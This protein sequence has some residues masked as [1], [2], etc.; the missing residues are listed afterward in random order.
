MEYQW[1]SQNTQTSWRPQEMTN[2]FKSIW[3]MAAPGLKAWNTETFSVEQVL[4]RLESQV[5]TQKRRLIKGLRTEPTRPTQNFNVWRRDHQS[6]APRADTC[7]TTGLS[8]AER[9]LRHLGIKTQQPKVS[10][11]D[12]ALRFGNLRR[13]WKTH[14]ATNLLTLTIYEDVKRP[15]CQVNSDLLCSRRSLSFHTTPWL[16]LTRLSW[17]TPRTSAPL[18]LKNHK[19]RNTIGLCYHYVITR[20][21]LCYH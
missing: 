15:S 13:P 17:L 2:D 14:S 1:I 7:P 9:L 8:R 18:P 12:N 20:L 5:T 4:F 11:S 3:A 21:S 10:K 16:K 19:G 6:A